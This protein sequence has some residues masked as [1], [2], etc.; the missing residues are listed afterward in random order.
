[1]KQPAVLVTG[2]AKRLGAAIV[3]RFADAGWHVLIHYNKSGDAAGELADRLPS[4]ET[5]Q[6]DLSDE[7]ALREMVSDLATR[8][9]NWRALVNCASIFKPDDVTDLDSET[10]RLAMQVN[11][12]SPAM[13]AQQY[14]A[15]ARA[16]GPRCVINVTDQ[17]LG[18][19]NPDF[20]SYTM[21]KAALSS[22]TRMLTLAFP[23]D[24][25]HAL[26]PG[27]ILPSHDQ[28]EEEAERSHRMNI[29][30]RRTRV[31]EVA[32]AAY[33][34]ATGPLNSGQNVAVDSGQHL[35]DQSRDVIYL[36][37]EQG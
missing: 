12:R 21:A 27:A 35:C 30:A 20:F 33:F 23:D 6:C 17:K 8:H 34:L 1:M 18:N 26:A 14:L 22:T 5:V 29:L 19:M 7:A 32:D 13:L 15:H 25:I 36:A 2:G 4:A 9:A 10:N 24:R 31:S 3:Q 37:R 28:S 11:A 16:K